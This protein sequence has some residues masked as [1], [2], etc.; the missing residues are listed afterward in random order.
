MHHDPSVPAQPDREVAPTRATSGQLDEL[1]AIAVE[2]RA[3]KATVLS[4][5]AKLADGR[6]LVREWVR[7]ATHGACSQRS[8]SCSPALHD[9]LRLADA[10]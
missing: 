7:G 6:Q 9:L 5:V 1:G 4:A 10:R 3:A 2:P 8:D